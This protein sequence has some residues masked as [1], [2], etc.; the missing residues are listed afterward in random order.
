MLLADMDRRRDARDP[1]ADDLSRMG[2]SLHG[3]TASAPAQPAAGGHGLI[4]PLDPNVADKLAYWM[5]EQGLSG[6][7]FSPMYY[8]GKDDWLTAEPAERMWKRA[9]QLGAVLNFFIATEQLPKLETMIRNI[10]RADDIDH[11]SQIDLSAADPLPEMKKLLA[12]CEVSERARESVGADIGFE[13][14]R[15]SVFRTRCRGSDGLRRIRPGATTVGH[16]LS[17]R[18]RAPLQ[19]SDAGR[20]IGLG[21]EKIPFFTPTIIEK[22]SAKTPRPCGS[23]PLKSRRRLRRRL[24]RHSQRRAATIGEPGRVQAGSQVKS[25]TTSRT[26]VVQQSLANPLFNAPTPLR[27]EELIDRPAAMRHCHQDVNHAVAVAD[28]VDIAH[29]NDVGVDRI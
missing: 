25:T 18:R 22:S 4:D 14:A 10:R 24:R 11:V 19:A 8:K 12:V 1:R 13:V 28:V 3:A 26:P 9:G 21:G 27:H 17:R 6:M 20:R 29:V 2:Q 5:Q 15:V 16:G 23:W 7:R